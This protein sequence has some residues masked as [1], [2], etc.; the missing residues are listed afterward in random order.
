MAVVSRYFCDL[1]GDELER[2]EWVSIKA[3]IPQRNCGTEGSVFE[4]SHVCDFC[5]GRVAGVLTR[6]SP[7]GGQAQGGEDA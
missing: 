2:G 6:R 5:R 4:F 3:I 7:Q 1:C